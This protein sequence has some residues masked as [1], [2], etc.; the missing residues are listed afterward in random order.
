M[1]TGAASFSDGDIPCS[2]EQEWPELARRLERFLAARGVERWLRAD[3]IQETAARLYPR[4]ETLDHSLPLWNLVVTIAVRIV[5]NHRRKES[6]IELVSDPHPIHQDDVHVRGLQRAQLDKT[7]SALRQLTADQRDVLLAEVGEAPLPAGTRTRIKVL[8]LRA[9]V[10]LREALGPWAP[11]AITIRLRY[12]RA[13]VAEKKSA[14]EM[15]APAIA[16][17]VVDV[18]VAATLVLAGAAID[19]ASREQSQPGRLRLLAE[20]RDGDRNRVANVRR[21]EAPDL[22]RAKQRAKQSTTG[23]SDPVTDIW[24]EAEKDGWRET[25]N[26]VWHQAEDDVWRET[27]KDV[28][29]ETEKDVWR[30]TEDDV[31]RET[32]KDVWRQAEDDIW[33][34]TG[35]KAEREVEKDIWGDAEKLIWRDAGKIIW[36]DGRKLIW[37]KA[38][39]LIWRKAGKAIW[40]DVEDAWP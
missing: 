17:S 27:E 22:P 1:A 26:D 30:E 21:P 28:W 4:W 3:V 19:V 34:D 38:G 25:E 10:K 12:L 29:R 23:M 8:R 31:W 5:H 2:F 14:F 16:S 33:R 37:S 39:K 11:S 7:R 20:V 32:E 13:R 15:H 24:R 36:R 35:G 18:A 9:R 6:R 40:R